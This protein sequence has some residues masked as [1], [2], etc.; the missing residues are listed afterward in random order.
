VCA[1]VWA[2]DAPSHPR[3]YWNLYS[4]QSCST[5]LPLTLVCCHGTVRLAHY[6]AL[7][8]GSTSMSYAQLEALLDPAQVAQLE[9]V[10]RHLLIDPTVLDKPKEKCDAES[11]PHDGIG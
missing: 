11:T 7:F 10:R 6:G 1:P 2:G 8:H 5:A 9:T 4:C 3:G